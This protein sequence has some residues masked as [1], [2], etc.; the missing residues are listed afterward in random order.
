MK[1]Y[2][3]INFPDCRGR[4][5]ESDVKVMTKDHNHEPDSSIKEKR[6]ILFEMKEEAVRS[7]C[8]ISNLYRNMSSKAIQEASCNA[9]NIPAYSKVKSPLYRARQKELPSLPSAVWN[10][11]LESE[12]RRKLIFDFNISF[13]PL[14][15]SMAFS[16]HALLQRVSHC[17]T[18][19][20]DGTFKCVPKFF[21]QLLTIHGYYLEE[22]HA[23]IQILVPDKRYDSYVEV[24]TQ[25]ANFMDSHDHRINDHTTVVTDFE[26]GLSNA[27]ARVFPQTTVVGC[28]F[29]YGQAI[30]RHVQAVGL[31]TDYQQDI[32]VKRTVHRIL[33]MPLVPPDMVSKNERSEMLH[34][35]MV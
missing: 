35:L 27:F 16:S 14:Q 10:I 8:G 6:R 28:T 33:S 21:C 23:L 7:T 4:A 2:R 5:K 15:R 3:C 32:E 22:W 29:H 9:E 11:E 20:V 1:Y 17:S 30:F 24:L 26:I 34:L 12:I 13:N 19:L 18:F 31:Q 25:L